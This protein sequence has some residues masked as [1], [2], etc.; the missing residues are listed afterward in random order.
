[1]STEG[2][3][4]SDVKALMIIEC[5][6]ELSVVYWGESYLGV[7]LEKRRKKVA[8]K[9]HLIEGNMDNLNE[10]AMRVRPR[11]K[12]LEIARALYRQ[13]SIYRKELLEYVDR[14]DK[15]IAWEQNGFG[16]DGDS[17]EQER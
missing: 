8:K 9:L 10:W 5:Q 15:W 12:Y 11:G 1:M 17:Q 3:Q 7:D 14:L 6:A 2:I 13:H 4:F 16:P